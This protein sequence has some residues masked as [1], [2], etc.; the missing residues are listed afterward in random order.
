MSLTLRSLVSCYANAVALVKCCLF[1]SST[2]SICQF[3]HPLHLTTTLNSLVRR[4]SDRTVLSLLEDKF[5]HKKFSTLMAGSFH[6]VLHT[7]IAFSDGICAIKNDAA[8]ANRSRFSICCA[9]IAA[10]IYLGPEARLGA[11]L[12][13]TLALIS[14]LKRLSASTTATSTLTVPFWRFASG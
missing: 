10:R 4:Q 5:A 11:F 2:A 7:E 13:T 12:I 8:P 9:V 6:C 14:G 3:G 1:E